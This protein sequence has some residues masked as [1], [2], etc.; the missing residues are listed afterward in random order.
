MLACDRVQIRKLVSDIARIKF[1]IM[2]S[3]KLTVTCDNFVASLTQLVSSRPRDSS[4]IF[5]L[6]KLRKLLCIAQKVTFANKTMTVISPY[7]A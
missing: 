3:I 7:I 5:L 6:G 4:E 2:I 1:I